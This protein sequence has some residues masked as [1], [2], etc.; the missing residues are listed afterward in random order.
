MEEERDKEGLII[1]YIRLLML[2]GARTE[3]G[4]V[5]LNLL[6]RWLFLSYEL[7]RLVELMFSMG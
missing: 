3:M 4:M 5:E 7:M 1:E 6:D 2:K